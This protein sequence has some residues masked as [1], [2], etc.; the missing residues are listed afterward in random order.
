MLIGTLGDTGADTTLKDSRAPATPE[1]IGFRDFEAM[2]GGM[3]DAT[4]G[5]LVLRTLGMELGRALPAT[6]A[7]VLHMMHV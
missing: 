6:H 1:A 5:D 7:L 3:T 2:I 4:Q